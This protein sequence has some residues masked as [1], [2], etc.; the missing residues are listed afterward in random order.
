MSNNG[1]RT[2]GRVTSGPA[3]CVTCG[4]P[5]TLH[6]NGTTPCKAS[7]C[8]AG[9]A[10]ICPSCNGTTISLATLGTCPRCEGKGTVPTP[11]REFIAHGQ[12]REVPELL[13]S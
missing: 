5:F 7:G 12:L 1:L 4:H 2:G 9:H 11:C 13:A 8:T 10:A 3:G 6:S